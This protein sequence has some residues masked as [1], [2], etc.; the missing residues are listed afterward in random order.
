MLLF[1]LSSAFAATPTELPPFLR[2]DIT[3]GY[4]FDYTQGGLQ[5]YVP[6]GS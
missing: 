4:A 1:A 3:I 5:E 6:Y 2:G